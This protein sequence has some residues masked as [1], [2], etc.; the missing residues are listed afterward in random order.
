L[1]AFW[2]I[3][4]IIWIFIANKGE[5]SDIVFLN[6]TRLDGSKCLEYILYLGIFEAHGDVFDVNVVDKLSL[7][8]LHI[9][10]L[11][12]YHMTNSVWL[13]LKGFFCKLNALVTYESVSS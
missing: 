6:N 7:G 3:F 8:F 5:F 2:S 11:E 1:S 9:F 12:F 10:W 13:V 4:F